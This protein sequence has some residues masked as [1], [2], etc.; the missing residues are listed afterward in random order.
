MGI[1]NIV[2]VGDDIL[3]K[4]SRPV[5]VINDKIVTLLDDMLETMR[6]HE[7]AGLAANQVGILRR[8]FVVE[9]EDQ[10]YE[11]INPEILDTRGE[12]TE[13][14][15]CLSVPG[16]VGTVTRPSYVKI[17]GQN[18]DGRWNEYE[19]EGLLA[20]AF[21]HEYDHLE[22]IMYIDKATDIHMAD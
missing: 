16:K 2:Q 18:R 12:I 5:D 3:R 20:K 19:A 11:M 14:E 17:K 1:R 8:I 15:A 22:G 21:L 13:E 9:V 7:G 4:K 10:V 6:E